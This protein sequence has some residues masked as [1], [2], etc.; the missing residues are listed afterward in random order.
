MTWLQ[1]DLKAIPSKMYQKNYDYLK[2]QL[3]HNSGKYANGDY[4]SQPE[5]SR[6]I[7]DPLNKSLQTFN[8]KMYGIP[9]YPKFS[10]DIEE[11]NNLLGAD[12]DAA[13][14]Y[15]KQ[16]YEEQMKQSIQTP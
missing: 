3:Q 4:K 9:T 14:E 13:R 12:N 10:N 2:I 1:E 15:F 5:Y 7:F 6:N 8:N 11:L 16:L